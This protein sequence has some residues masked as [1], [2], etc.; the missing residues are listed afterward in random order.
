MKTF[1]F[2]LVASVFLLSSLGLLVPAT[3]VEELPEQIPGWGVATNWPTRVLDPGQSLSV[4]VTVR[5]SIV[6]AF[7]SPEQFLRVE[8]IIVGI[9]REPD[10]VAG[11]GSAEIFFPGGQ[12]EVVREF[13]VQVSVQE[14]VDPGRYDFETIVGASL[15][16]DTSS[17][18][19]TVRTGALYDSGSVWI[20]GEEQQEITESLGPVS[21]TL[22]VVFPATA[23]PGDTVTGEATIIPDTTIQQLGGEFTVEGSKLSIERLGISRE[24]VPVGTS[25]TGVRTFPVSVDIPG[26]AEPGTYAWT[27]SAKATGR[28]MLFSVTRPVTVSGSFEVVEPFPIAEGSVCVIATAAFGSE[29]DA[30]V[31]AMRRL[32]DDRVMTTFTGSNF[33]QAFNA[34]YYSWSPPVADLIRTNEILR[35]AA[36]LVLYPV[37]ASV[38][39]AEKTYSALPFNEELAATASILTAASIS[40]AAYI[41]PLILALGFISERLH[42]RNPSQAWRHKNHLI[43]FFF[44]AASALTLLGGATHSA[45]LNTIGVTTLAL[46]TTVSIALVTAETVTRIRERAT[47]ILVRQS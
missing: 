24:I 35:Q 12:V 15:M 28:A 36:R 5:P 13:S 7:L 42:L 8:T 18:I 19:R 39:A 44:L 31:E 14:P 34:W 1:K 45:E 43:L 47:A 2:L 20:G 40:G 32:R 9:F 16:E 38:G 27:A 3:G 41:A 29:M 37:V 23:Q 17:G 21:V 25:F 6:E 26:D 46:A 10:V 22:K 33:M 30:N 4:K 11:G